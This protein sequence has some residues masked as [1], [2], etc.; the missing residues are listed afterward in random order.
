MPT[1]KSPASSPAHFCR[2]PTHC[3]PNGCATV[4]WLIWFQLVIPFATSGV[5]VEM[6]RVLDWASL[7]HTTRKGAMPFLS[8]KEMGRLDCSVTN[9]KSD[10]TW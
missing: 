2:F 1:S 3:G 7:P 9:S 4:R 5:M 6:N 10:P 8:F